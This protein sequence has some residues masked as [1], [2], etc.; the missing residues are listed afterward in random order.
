MEMEEEKENGG[1]Q[2]LSNRGKTWTEECLVQWGRIMK[3][4]SPNPT[5]SRSGGMVSHRATCTEC[6]QCREPSYALFTH[7]KE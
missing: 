1:K 3:G 6:F 7:S 5:S 2:V 4:K